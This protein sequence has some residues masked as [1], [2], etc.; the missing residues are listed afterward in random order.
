MKELPR[1][2]T[3]VIGVSLFISLVSAAAIDPTWES[4]A[5]NYEV[6]QWLVDGK[7]GVWFHWGISSASVELMGSSETIKWKRSADGLTIRLPKTLPDSLVVGF[8]LMVQ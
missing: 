6:P 2:F 5:E 3:T 4:L 8:K 7:L 1:R